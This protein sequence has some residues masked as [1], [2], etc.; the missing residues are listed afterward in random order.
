[1]RE[2]KVREI[3]ANRPEGRF[4]GTLFFDAAGAHVSLN[5]I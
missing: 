2:V 5:V 3:K 4:D 1:M